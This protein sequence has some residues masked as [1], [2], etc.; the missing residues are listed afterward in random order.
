[1]STTKLPWSNFL[2]EVNGKMGFNPIGKGDLFGTQMVPRQR[3][4][5]WG[6]WLWYNTEA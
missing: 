3:Y 4:K 2:T 1:M 5:S 6:V